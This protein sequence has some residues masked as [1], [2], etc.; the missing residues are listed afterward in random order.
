MGS[1]RSAGRVFLYVRVCVLAIAALGL[2]AH[3]SGQGLKESAPKTTEVLF[4]SD[5]HFEP[6]LDPGKAV[7]LAAAPVSEWESILVG[8]ATADAAAQWAKVEQSCPTRGADT[9]FVLYRSSLTAMHAQA[10]HAKFAVVS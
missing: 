4:V 10:S 3:A 6:F 8:P 5:I 9:S 7:K 2:A 1:F